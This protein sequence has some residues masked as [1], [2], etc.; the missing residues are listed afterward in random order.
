MATTMLTVNPDGLSEREQRL[1]DA[2]PD[3]AS[4]DLRSAGDNRVHANVIR[5]LLL[6]A[7][8]PGPGQLPGLELYGAHIL[9]PLDLA[10]AD[11]RCSVRL[12]ACHFD[13]PMD[14]YGARMRRLSLSESVFPGFT[15]SRALIDGNLQLTRCK[16]T[17]KIRLF[18]AR[19]AGGL[20]LDRAQVNSSGI[21]LDGT[22]LE[23]ASDIVGQNGFECVGS[24]R[25][26][27][28]KVGGALRLEDARLSNPGGVALDARNLTVG[29]VANCCD[30]FQ[31]DGEVQ[32]HYA[33][34]YNSLC[35]EN[36]KLS[37][38]GGVA[39][40]GRYLDTNRLTL[41]PAPPVDGNIDLRYARIGLL[42]DESSRWPK[43]LR[44]DGLRYGRLWDTA[45]SDA[46]PARKRL[47]W[48]HL[49]PHRYL[50]QAYEQLASMYERLGQELDARTVRLEKQ[51]RRR[52]LLPPVGKLWGYVQDVTIGYGYRPMRAAAWLGA[53]LALGSAF[54]AAL[55]PRPVMT[56][57]TPDFNPLVYTL[58]L[59][60]PIVDFG[61]EHALNPP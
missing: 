37:N 45:L 24:L 38:P 28:A 5:M 54:F 27:N 4:V 12:E 2:Y 26:L 16:S 32:L 51:R 11:I 6:G 42:E 10:F 23:V 41:R 43:A 1:W 21:A 34:I 39:L 31:A 56:T 57:D 58:D 46:G 14:F 52:S 20:L 18:G 22:L 25:L 61:Q 7:R 53:L 47:R 15:A 60:L 55:P 19:V 36:A 50:P 9:G 49:D 29:T 13:H 33:K 8:T 48:I 40:N 59:L 3:G 17:D 30:G 35:V 44:I